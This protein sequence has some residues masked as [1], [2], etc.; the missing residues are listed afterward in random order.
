MN[1]QIRALYL[2]ER[3]WHPGLTPGLWWKDDVRKPV[4]L[5]D[6]F[7]TQVGLDEMCLVVVLEAMS[8]SCKSVVRSHVFATWRQEIGEAMQEPESIAALGRA[9]SEPTGRDAIRALAKAFRELESEE[10]PHG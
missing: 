8:E 7:R 10:A 5:E 9:R 3:G 1:D 4:S 6:A 2:R